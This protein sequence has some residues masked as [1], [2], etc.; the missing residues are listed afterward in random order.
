MRGEQ[1]TTASDIYSLGVVLY[2]LLTE[3]RPFELKTDNFEEM[4]RIVSTSEPARPSDISRISEES[5]HNPKSKIQNPKLLKG[6]LDSIAL[7]SLGKE[8]SAPLSNGR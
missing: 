5:A 7:K 3:H 2:E 4:L 8:P 1:V 6:D